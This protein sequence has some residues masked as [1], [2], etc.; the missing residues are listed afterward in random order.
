M[1]SFVC[2]I[3]AE[4]LLVH[5]LLSSPV[6][7]HVFPVPLQ[8]Q[9]P[10]GPLVNVIEFMDQ[11]TLRP[12]L[13]GSLLIKLNCHFDIGRENTMSPMGAVITLERHYLMTS[14]AEHLPKSVRHANSSPAIAVLP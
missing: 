3:L 9:Q 6:F 10:S 8:S 14:V 2:V 11:Q 7:A 12:V 1:C 5:M 4:G 13:S